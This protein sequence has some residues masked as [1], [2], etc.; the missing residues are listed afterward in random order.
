MGG[1]NVYFRPPHLQQ[2]SK[3]VNN[4]IIGLLFLTP[5]ESNYPAYLVDH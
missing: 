5:A 1:D 3:F 2:Q 4:I